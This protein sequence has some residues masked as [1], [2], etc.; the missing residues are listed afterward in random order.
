MSKS[1]SKTGRNMAFIESNSK[2]AGLTSAVIG[3]IP[4]GLRAAAETYCTFE[5]VFHIV[6][7]QISDFKHIEL[8]DFLENNGI[9]RHRKLTLRSRLKSLYSTPI[10]FWLAFLAAAVSG[11]LVGMVSR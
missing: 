1:K 5:D 3:P 8:V 2:P 11:A 10:Q 9:R 4:A 7:N 6:N